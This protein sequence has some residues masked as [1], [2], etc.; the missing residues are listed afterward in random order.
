MRSPDSWIDLS[1]EQAI[2]FPSRLDNYSKQNRKKK[3]VLRFILAIER[4]TFYSV[5][6]KKIISEILFR[7]CFHSSVLISLENSDEG[8]VL[9]FK[10]PCLA[11]LANIIIRM[12]WNN[13]RVQKVFEEPFLQHGHG[14]FGEASIRG[15]KSTRQVVQSRRVVNMIIIFNSSP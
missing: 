6:T 11:K 10:C 8:V 9:E 4:Y 7:Y 5:H 15:T 12:K 2:A 3:H 13:L 1:A 14:V